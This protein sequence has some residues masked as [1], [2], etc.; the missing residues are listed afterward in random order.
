M[1]RVTRQIKRKGRGGEKKDTA[2]KKRHERNRNGNKDTKKISIIAKCQIKKSKQRRQ[3][4]K[5]RTYDKERKARKR[6][7]RY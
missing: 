3:K 1:I 7:R 2:I 4:E 6:N 5:K